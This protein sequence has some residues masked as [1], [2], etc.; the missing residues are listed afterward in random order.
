MAYKMGYL[1]SFFH[2]DPFGVMFIPRW[3]KVRLMPTVFN[4]GCDL[5]YETYGEGEPLILAH[6]AGGNT[7]CWWQQIPFFADH[8]KVIV[9]DHRGFSRSKVD[10][11]LFDI[12]YFTNDLRAI[13]DKEEIESARLVCQSMGGWTGLGLALESPEKVKALVM[14]HTTGGIS[15]DETDKIMKDKMKSRSLPDS[16]YAHWALAPDFHQKNINAANLYNQIGLFNTELDM[17]KL[18][19]MLFKPI[20]LDRLQN[21]DIPTLFITANQEQVFPAEMII[22][23]AELVPGAKIENLGDAGH[24]SYFESPDL[25]NETVSKFLDAL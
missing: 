12:K 15:S 14:S 21:F 7:A 8:Y 13:M 17:E 4:E 20:N 16:P 22:K 24:S 3:E 9:F 18:G 19:S 11:A 6:G 23:V 5:Y 1:L 25:F 2:R 10:A